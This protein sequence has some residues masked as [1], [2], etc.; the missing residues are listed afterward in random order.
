VHTSIALQATLKGLSRL[1]LDPD[2]L[3]QDLQD[4]RE[5]LAEAIQTVM[6]RYGIEKP[7]E[8]LKELTRGQKI[9]PETLAAFIK[10]L[11]LPEPAKQ[12]LLALTPK[13][14]LGYARELAE[15]V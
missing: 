6:R 4:N 1:E 10:T 9:S 11:D 2:R 3:I 14:Y 15:N 5:V 12:R 13:D 8:Q 7:Y